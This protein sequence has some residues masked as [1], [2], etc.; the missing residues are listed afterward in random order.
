LFSCCRFDDFYNLSCS[1][2]NVNYFCKKSFRDNDHIDTFP[3]SCV[4]SFYIMYCISHIHKDRIFFRLLVFSDC[5]G[6]HRNA[7]T[8]L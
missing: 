4:F 2:M 7:L 8:I 3:Y 5:I 6:A 1:E